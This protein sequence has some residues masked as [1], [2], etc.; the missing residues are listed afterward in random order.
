M[1]ISSYIRKPFLIYMTLHPIPFEFPYTIYEE[2]CDSFL[3][4]YYTCHSLYLGGWAVERHEVMRRN[5][6][7]DKRR[8]WNR[9][10][11]TAAVQRCGR[12]RRRLVAVKRRRRKRR[13]ADA[14]RRMIDRVVVV[15]MHA[16]AVVIEAKHGGVLGRHG[17]EGHHTFR[18][19]KIRQKA[20]LKRV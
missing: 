3:S 20:M 15:V 1:W 13:I 19:P 7:A 2:N 4:V 9:L 11:G 12:R 14:H 16:A 17:G 8:R 6:T 10:P 18:R 5:S